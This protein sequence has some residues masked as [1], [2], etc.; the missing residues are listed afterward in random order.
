MIYWN[1]LLK[2]ILNAK[3]VVIY[4]AG[5]MGKAVKKCLEEAPYYVRIKAFLVKSLEDNPDEIDGVP[6]MNLANASRYQDD[7]ILVALHEKNIKGVLNLLSESG[8]RYVKPLSFDSD[9][10]SDIRGNWFQYCG[11]GQQEDYIN[12]NK[13]VSEKF[14]IYVVHSIADQ[15]L[16]EAME[17]RTFEIPIQVGAALTD[18]RIAMVTDNQ[19]E[20]ISE[21]NKKYCE[22]TALYWIWKNDHAK[23]VG[24]SH[25]RR[26][27]DINE[28]MFEWIQKSDID[29]ILT[30]PV[31]NLK[32]LVGNTAMTIL[33]LTGML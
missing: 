21:K 18:K 8:F 31:L 29:V 28:Q 4:G 14:R 6:V 24:L 33:S 13:L 5:T 16:E 19:G 12:L 1:E 20:N 10:W 11:H 17:D 7:L 15:V 25:Y 2:E 30:V 9:E 27:F 22:L 26:R 3:Q 23:Y 32:G